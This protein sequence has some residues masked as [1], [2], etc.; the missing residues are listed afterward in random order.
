MITSLFRN[1]AI[2]T[3]AS[4]QTPL[5]GDSQGKVDSI[6]RGA[7]LCR[8]GLIEKIGEEHAV[9]KDLS[10]YDVD[11]EIDC[12]GCCLIPGFVDPHTHICFAAR[13]ER[14]FSQR[15]AGT[16]Y[17]DILRAGGGILS[18]VRAVKEA[19]E[20]ELFQTTLENVLSAL[21]F[22]TTTI[23]IKS[24]YGLD[25]ETELKMLRVIDRIRRETPLDV[26]ITFM[27][28]HAVPHEYKEDPDTFV[29]ILTDEMIPAVAKQGIARFCDVFCEEGVFTLQQS[30][31]ILQSAQK[32]GLKPRIHADEVYD[33]GGAGLAAE[34]Q[35]VSAE[36]L[37]AASERNLKAMAE[38]K[39]IANLLPATAY[40]LRKPYA[41]AR[42][43][44]E[45]NV[46]V[47]LATDCNPGSCFT[48]SMPFVFGLAVMNMNMTV[49]EALVASTINAAWALEMQH[50]VGSLEV[51]KQADFLLLD[52]DSPA[53]L[54]YHAGVSPVVSVYK[55]GVLVA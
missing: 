10:L 33:T 44:I 5:S 43:M 2:Y 17:L 32:H 3:P 36:H 25:T 55:K 1:A 4:S 30:R 40:S 23:E 28:A 12:E 20:E 18:S 27:G 6:A 34:L 9:I 13:R 42:R 31:K 8:N 14:E 22:G 21:S 15:I 16:P 35:T 48:E 49:Q 19:S 24:G 37:L 38:A 29:S 53:I 47:A 50:S 54:A 46:P 52:G 26:A 7:L 51:G 11:I 41:P 45:L 39:V